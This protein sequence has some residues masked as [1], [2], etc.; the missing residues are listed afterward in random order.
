MKILHTADLHLGQIMYQYYDRVDEHDHFFGQLR[1]W[2][3]EYQPDALLV[4]GDVF[5][6]PQPGAST[7]EH[8]NQMVADL[9]REFPQ[10]AIVI[11]A[12]NHD[13]AARLQADSVVWQL[14]GVTMVGQAPPTDVL[15]RKDGWQDDYIV[16]LKS[17]FV[18]AMP[19]TTGSRKDVVQALLDYVDG[20]NTDGKPVVMCGHL[21]LV[22]V[23]YKGHGDI[24]NQRPI[25]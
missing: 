20:R 4:C 7:K 5:D 6:I 23:D 9:H 1:G 17:G 22:G 13:S 25:L 12:G 3:A 8:F 15:Q 24:G 21:A 14:S 10:M 2:C 18:V 19:F 11:I 16:E